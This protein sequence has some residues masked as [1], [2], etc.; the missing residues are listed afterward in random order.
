M[1]H[2]WGFWLMALTFNVHLFTAPDVFL[3]FG[4]LHPS[5]A[6]AIVALQGVVQ[7]RMRH[8]SGGL[9][10][11]REPFLL[12]ALGSLTISNPGTGLTWHTVDVGCAPRS[13]VIYLLLEMAASSIRAGKGSLRFSFHWTSLWLPQFHSPPGSPFTFGNKSASHTGKKNGQEKKR[14]PIWRE[15][16]QQWAQGVVCGVLG[17]TQTLF[18][19]G[20]ARR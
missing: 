20:S 5:R 12:L 18:F 3:L 11:P 19:P 16:K 6:H 15:T 17:R 9:C 8:G 2:L 7:S 10:I 14:T 13:M 1:F 4:C